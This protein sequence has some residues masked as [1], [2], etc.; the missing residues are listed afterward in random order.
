M[1]NRGK[2]I[3]ILSF[4]ILFI[5]WTIFT[6]YCIA[7]DEYAAALVSLSTMVIMIALTVPVIMKK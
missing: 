1:S 5:Y 2:L 7:N 3:L 6:T 4:V